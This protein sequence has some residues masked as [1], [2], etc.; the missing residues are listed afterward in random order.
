MCEYR[1]TGS[2]AWIMTPWQVSPDGGWAKPPTICVEGEE[3]H[4]PER[5]Q[6]AIGILMKMH[7]RPELEP[8]PI[9]TLIGELQDVLDHG[10]WKELT[11]IGAN[12]LVREL[13]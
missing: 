11:P 13:P 9:H 3:F 8:K 12:G 4:R 2:K 6:D 1:N 10:L 7:Q 5:P